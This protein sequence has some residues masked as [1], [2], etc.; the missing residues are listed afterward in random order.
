[1]RKK[2]DKTQTPGT[3]KQNVRIRHGS[4]YLDKKYI[5]VEGVIEKQIME[6]MGVNSN[7]EILAGYKVKLKGYK[8]SM[9]FYEDELEMI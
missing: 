8:K 7:G 9:M 3:K 4:H 6:M 1:M 5:G 2:Q